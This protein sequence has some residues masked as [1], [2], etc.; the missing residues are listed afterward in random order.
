M[1]IEIEAGRLGLAE[2]PAGRGDEPVPVEQ[3]V[4]V[5]RRADIPERGNQG[6]GAGY[7]EIVLRQAA[8]RKARAAAPTTGA[9]GRQ[10]ELDRATT[11]ARPE[12]FQDRG[13]QGS[14]VFRDQVAPGSPDDLGLLEPHRALG[15]AQ[16]KA[17]ALVGVDFQEKI[18][19]RKGEAQVARG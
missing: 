10:L 2:Q 1:Q 15:G 14:I 12:P 13:H 3:A 11:R 4:L 16:G 5:L 19:A 8:R 9:G 17:D 18:G 6:Q 7:L